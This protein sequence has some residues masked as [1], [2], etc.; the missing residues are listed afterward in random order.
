MASPGQWESAVSPLSTSAAQTAR[1]RALSSLPTGRRSRPGA[2]AAAPSDLLG[3]Y[4]WR[5]FF[6]DVP[7]DERLLRAS[8]GVR[9][10]M[11]S[12]FELRQGAW[13]LSLTAAG[14]ELGNWVY[15]EAPA[16]LSLAEF[17]RRVETR[18]EPC[19]ACTHQARFPRLRG[20]AEY[21]LRDGAAVFMCPE[22]TLAEAP[23]AA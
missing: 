12:A 19:Q 16:R 14:A 17:E 6:T 13:S 20:W 18:L 23:A 21:R 1:R 3:E 15:G 5:R 9:R 8:A 2:S 4:V 22:C 11:R 7:W 10:G